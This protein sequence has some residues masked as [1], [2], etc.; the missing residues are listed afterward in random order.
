MKLFEDMKELGGTI[1]DVI[2]K[3]INDMF[4]EELDDDEIM[5]LVS[6]LSLSDLLALDDAYS[7]G[8]K[9]K[10]QDIL[11]PLPQ[12]E[13]SMG[14]SATSAASTRP[15]ARTAAAPQAKKQ[16]TTTQSTSNYSG[17]V[18]NGVSTTNIDDETPNDPNAV[19]QDDEPVEESD[20]STPEGWAIIGI[21]RYGNEKR[22]AVEEPHKKQHA[23]EVIAK[24]L[25]GM[26][27]GTSRGGLLQ[28]Y[29]DARIEPYYEEPIEESDYMKRRKDSEDQIS[30]KKKPKPA[31]KPT[32]K[33][34][35]MKRR[36]VEEG[37]PGDLSGYAANMK[38]QAEKRKKK[39]K[40]PW[41][42]DEP[43][44]SEKQRAWDKAAK[45]DTME[46]GVMDFV[47]QQMM[48]KQNIIDA[49]YRKTDDQLSKDFDLYVTQGKRGGI[50]SRRKLEFI[51]SE[52][53]KEMTRRGISNTVEEGAPDYNPSRGG[54]DDFDLQQLAQEYQATMAGMGH[55]NSD[56]IIDDMYAI[57]DEDTV[58][59]LLAFGIEEAGAP[60]YNP[61]R[62]GYGS[63]PSEEFNSDE[64]RRALETAASEEEDLHGL[65]LVAHRINQ[66]YP[67]SVTIADIMDML[68]EPE[69]RSVRKDDVEY[70]LQAAGIMDMMESTE[71]QVEE[72]VNVVEMTEWL[73]RRAG[74]A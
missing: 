22:L 44:S 49:I 47:D 53:E 12:M 64:V 1:N 65:Q 68:N 17:G 5:E 32:A 2:Q 69:L 55:R 9:E 71:E 29:V 16:N 28:G 56:D 11:G 37:R 66:S 72:T 63:D 33:T 13:Y 43:L 4:R 15:A 41:K 21:D 19:M 10:V 35:Y 24:S 51:R 62:G 61:S 59:D 38:K 50:V 23:E 46:S 58:D 34:D 70:A 52:L 74:I 40:D 36:G 45:A 57:A 39:P 25:M 31:P 14:G 20:D 6:K 7:N 67:D 8:D 73:K 48:T 26:K 3:M 60:D 27:A 18:Q 54:N 30:G 42:S